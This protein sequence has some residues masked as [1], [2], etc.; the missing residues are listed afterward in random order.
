VLFTLVALT[1]L[2]AQDFRVPVPSIE[3]TAGL[4]RVLLIGDS[5]SI[6]YGL[7]V[8]KLL[9]GK[10]NVHRI[11][12][13]G[14]TSANGV[15]MVDSWLGKEKWDVIHFNFGLHDLKRLED[16]EPQVPIDAYRRYLRLFA[17]RLKQTGAKLI[18]AT[19]TPVPEGKVSPPRRP[20]DVVAYNKVA[21]EVMLENGIAVNDLYGFALPRLDKIQLPVNVHFTNDGSEQLAGRVAEAIHRLIKSGK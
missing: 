14:G 5:I 8:R 2:Q 20:M 21:L 15:F 4:P 13:N 11:P 6:G 3:D 7:P 17:K 9:A 1:L 19:T 10:A 16:G 18:F 12:A